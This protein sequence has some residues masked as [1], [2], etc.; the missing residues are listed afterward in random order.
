MECDAFRLI[1]ERR[2][3]EGL[4]ALT[5]NQK[6]RNAAV[7]HS[8]WMIKNNC[9][10]H[11]CPG[12]PTLGARIT[13]AGYDWSSIG[14]TIAAGHKT[15]QEVVDAWMLSPGHRDILLGNFREVGL[16]LLPCAS[17]CRYR[18]YWTADFG[19]PR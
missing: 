18:T 8:D 4:A 3:T 11:E 15:A 16:S 14:E 6:L 10:D 7:F 9:F 12:E 1:N 5:F 2:K 19:R 13:S 17:G